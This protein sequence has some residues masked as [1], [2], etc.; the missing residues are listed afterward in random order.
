MDTPLPRRLKVTI[1]RNKC[2]G[3]TMCIQYAPLVFGLDGRKQSAVINADGDTPARIREAA[4]QC[5]LSAVI[6]EDAETG[7]QVFP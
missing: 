7:E 1:D 3:S 4:E 5:P 6:L 2:V